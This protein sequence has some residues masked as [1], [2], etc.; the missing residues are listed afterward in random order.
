[1]HPC[2]VGD[3]PGPLEFPARR[4][5]GA[6]PPRVDRGPVCP[7]PRRCGGGCT[8]YRSDWTCPTGWRSPRSISPTTSRKIALPSPG[9]H[10]QLA[11]HLASLST[12]HLDRARPRWERYLVHGLPGGRQ[13]L[14]T[15]VHHAALDGLSGAE[16]VAALMD[17]A[18]RAPRRPPTEGR[19]EAGHSARHRRHDRPSGQDTGHPAGPECWPPPPGWRG[20]RS[21]RR[22]PGLGRRKAGAAGRDGVHRR[23]TT[24]PAR[25]T[26]HPVQRPE[27][28]PPVLRVH[29]AA[30]GG[31]QGGEERG[32]RFHR[33]RRGPLSTTWSWRGVRRWCGA[34][35]S[36]HDALPEGPLVAAMPVSV[37][38]PDQQGRAGNPI[39]CM[40][41]ALPTHE[42][43]PPDASPDA[44]PVCTPA[45]RRRQTTVPG[46]TAHFA[47]HL[48]RRPAPAAARGG[49]PRRVPGRHPGRIRVQRADLPRPRPPVSAFR[50]GHPDPRALPPLRGHRHQRR[51]PHHRHVR[52]RAPRFRPDRLPRHG[53]R[54]LDTDR[55]PA[56][57]PGRTDHATRLR[58]DTPR[59]RGRRDE[60]AC[61][62]PDAPAPGGGRSAVSTTRTPIRVR[63]PSST[64]GEGGNA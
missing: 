49:L 61:P 7:W 17:L 58:G 14:D 62:S 55:I 63:A 37:R 32:A 24:A 51:P 10:G 12:A 53:P 29:L 13:A 21:R 8:R 43:N 39:S 20:E 1:M 26:G 40:L 3:H 44:S 31:D 50:R 41:A 52:S 11:E 64:V 42:P 47:A 56:G 6:G 15:K 27:H 45:A 38:T 28:R 35:C 19:P 5:D 18:P 57:R 4:G 30:P 59:R 54:H 36:A 23:P 48:Q 33:Q 46:P 25:T 60:P 16:I 34:G 9:T 22:P 2:R